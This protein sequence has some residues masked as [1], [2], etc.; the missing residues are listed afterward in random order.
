MKVTIVSVFLCAIIVSN[1]SGYKILGVFHPPAKSH[2]IVGHA[3]MKGLAEA[4]HEVTIITPFKEKNPIKNY[5]EVY[6]KHS[7]EE[8]IKGTRAGN[9]L[10]FNNMPFWKLA[11]V[12]ADVSN[13]FTINAI[14]DEAFQ[15]FLREDRQFD[16][17]IAEVFVGD[18]LMALGHY[19][20]APVIGF[21]TTVAS[22]WT[23]DLVGL[24]HF[25]SH[26]PNII[27][28]YSGEMTFTQRLWN[29]LSYWVE[30]FIAAVYYKP[31]QQKYLETYW[32]NKTSAPSLAEVQRNIAAVFVNSH[33]TY[34]IPQPITSNLI[35]IGGIHINRSDIAYTEDVQAFLD[36][37]KDGAIFLSLGSN[38]KLSKVPANIKKMIANSFSEF[39]NVRIL[40]KNEEDFDVPSHKKSDLLIKPWFNQQEILAH[41]NLRVFFS[42]GGLLS[43]TEAVHFGKPMVGTPLFFDQYL[44]M[45]MAESKG[46]GIS[47]PYESLSEEKL[48]SAIRAVLTNPSY[49][50]TA[51][52]LS[53]R[54][55]DQIS[56]PMETA[57]H[58]AEH[59]AK[60]KGASH[61]RSPGLDLPFIV[62]YNLDCYAFLLFVCF[63]VIYTTYKVISSIYQ[64]ILH[65]VSYPSSKVKSH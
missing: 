36:G 58:W 49:A 62:F 60:F 39:P 50:K 48:K 8:A 56:T 41:P 53:D 43:T 45:K 65:K 9:F 37:A 24:S 23:N 31:V 17:V 46:Y 54:L 27:C 35:E 29:S 20:N 64:F 2:Y 3:L 42:H 26:T 30:D 38:I 15:Q 5:E 14:R 18:A 59:I 16:L 4:G 10:N 32:P 6:L 55:H 47:V 11:K 61:L 22:K 13:N 21:T 63:L 34:T 19:F 40:I 57:V 52:D 33:V 44:N 7:L 1:V 51:K 28:G 25:A 12:L